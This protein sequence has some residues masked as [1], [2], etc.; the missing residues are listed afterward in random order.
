MPLAAGQWLRGAARG[1]AVRA[2]RHGAQRAHGA[3]GRG[4]GTALGRWGGPTLAALDFSTVVNSEA[5]KEGVGAGRGGRMVRPAGAGP[6]IPAGTAARGCATRKAGQPDAWANGCNQPGC[7]DCVQIAELV[8]VACA[9]D[10]ARARDEQRAGDAR[11]DRERVGRARPLLQYGPREHEDDR[12][13]EEGDRG[14]V[15]D[16]KIS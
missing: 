3:A 16:V 9:E 15:A 5:K 1:A 6:S 7:K 14:V 4:G 2:Q 8:L 11:D 13:V 12:R 10:A